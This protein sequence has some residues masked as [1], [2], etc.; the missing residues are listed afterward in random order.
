MGGVTR[1]I[2]RTVLAPSEAGRGRMGSGDDD[3]LPPR[4]GRVHSPPP[5]RHSQSCLRGGG[6][7]AGQAPTTM[8]GKRIPSIPSIPST[9]FGTT[10]TK[11]RWMP[12][13][14][15]TRVIRRPRR[16]P[17]RVRHLLLAPDALDSESVIDF[18]SG[19]RDG[20]RP[21]LAACVDRRSLK[22]RRSVTTQ[23]PW[24]PRFPQAPWPRYANAQLVAA[25][26]PRSLVPYPVSAYESPAPQR[27]DPVVRR[28]RQGRL[29]R[30]ARGAMR[31]PASDHAW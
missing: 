28:L 16:L 8:N 27:R 5:F 13:R 18:R 15:F 29:G 6:E 12:A 17:Q 30:A 21:A 7:G 26:G 23:S 25:R 1:G 31:R 10:W 19:T 3:P 11:G 22:V 4:L 14:S 2:G 20:G 24:E 9:S